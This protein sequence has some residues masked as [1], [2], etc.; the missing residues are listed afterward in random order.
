MLPLTISPPLYKHFP[1]APL[2]IL[3]IVTYHSFFLFILL[4]RF[5]VCR[6]TSLYSKRKT[7]TT[8]NNNKKNNTHTEIGFFFFS[9]F[10]RFLFLSPCSAIYDNVRRGGTYRTAVVLCGFL[11]TLFRGTPHDDTQPPTTDEEGTVQHLLRDS[12]SRTLRR[13]SYGRCLRCPCSSFLHYLFFFGSSFRPSVVC[14]WI[15]VDT[16]GRPLISSVFF[17][18]FLV[19]VV[20]Q[21]LPLSLFSRLFT[22]RAS[23][24][25]GGKTNQRLHTGEKRDEGEEEGGEGAGL[26]LSATRARKGNVVKWGSGAFRAPFFFLV[27]SWCF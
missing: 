5:T 23:P 13:D 27:L 16:P 20:P 14:S 25:R 22:E 15:N 3:Y 2:F 18:F 6:H 24:A 26:A 12:H 1:T 8:K 10:F 9:L 21:R 7:T 17:P 4:L 11:T 19:V